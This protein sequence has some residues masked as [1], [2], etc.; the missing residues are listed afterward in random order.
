MKQLPKEITVCKLE[1]VLMPQGEIICMGK[2][3]GWFKDLGSCLQPASIDTDE[4]QRD[5]L[6]EIVRQFIKGYRSGTA[7]PQSWLV[8]EAEKLVAKLE[9]ERTN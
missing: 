9:Y 6:L 2:T 1:C 7:I 5:D 4:Q 8:Q 3:V